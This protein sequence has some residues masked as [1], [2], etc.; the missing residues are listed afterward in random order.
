[1]TARR[2]SAFMIALAVALPGVVGCGGDSVDLVPVTGIVTLNGQPFPGAEISF[3]PAADAPGSTTGMDVTG[4]EG[5]YKVQYKGRFGLAPGKYVVLVTKTSTPGGSSA[6][7]PQMVDDAGNP[8]GEDPMMAEIAAA[9]AAEGAG[10]GGAASQAAVTKVQETFEREVPAE[11]GTFDFDVK[12]TA[13]EA[14]IL[15]GS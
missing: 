4:P 6:G 11:G 2:F 1:M 14:K 15:R 13:E 5:N 9:S 7:M 3:T 10:R 12:A 8:I